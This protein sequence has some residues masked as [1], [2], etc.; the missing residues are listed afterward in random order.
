M[1]ALRRDYLNVTRGHKV[2]WRMPGTPGYTDP[3][4]ELEYAM[5]GCAQDLFLEAQMILG[6]M[7]LNCAYV[8]PDNI[9]HVD[10]A[11]LFFEELVHRAFPTGPGPT[12]PPEGCHLRQIPR[13]VPTPDARIPYHIL[14]IVENA[15]DTDIFAWKHPGDTLPVPDPAWPNKYTKAIVT[16]GHVE[17]AVRPRKLPKFQGMMPFCMQVC[18]MHGD[19]DFDLSLENQKK[20]KTD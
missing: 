12:L 16:Q 17:L 7:G 3:T 11:E 6:S 1:R 2:V 9:Q 10:F 20:E 5:Q 18:L 14:T 15:Q 19:L 13:H 4:S 8:Q